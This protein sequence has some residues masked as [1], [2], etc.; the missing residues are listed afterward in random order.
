VA[1]DAT[2]G[3]ISF[4][5]G[6]MITAF[7]MTEAEHMVHFNNLIAWLESPAN[8]CQ[9]N[10]THSARQTA[11]LDERENGLKF[12]YPEDNSRLTRD[13]PSYSAAEKLPFDADKTEWLLSKWYNEANQGEV[14][15]YWGQMNSRF[16]NASEFA[17]PAALARKFSSL[18]MAP[19]AGKFTISLG[20][21]EGVLE[22]GLVR[23]IGASAEEVSTHPSV[24]FAGLFINGFGGSNVDYNPMIPVQAAQDIAFLKSYL[25][26]AA[27]SAC[28]EGSASQW[29]EAA[30]KC[31]TDALADLAAAQ[32]C[33]Q[34]VQ[35]CLDALHDIDLSV[36]EKLMEL[37]PG[38]GAYPNEA[39]FFQKDWKTEFWGSNYAKLEKVKK[40]VDPDNLFQCH[41]C[42]GSE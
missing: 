19:G 30:A 1:R 27:N 25:H 21:A 37:W 4:A 12:A 28:S 11:I 14:F 2:S 10:V 15:T 35:R 16:V 39:S 29:A 41:H 38:M 24:R 18:V 42:I 5:E 17:D 3:A 8:P 32:A 26:Q 40:D 31:S 33:D 7:N 34:V 23:S 36:G 20:K 9:A 6:T 13:I 22:D